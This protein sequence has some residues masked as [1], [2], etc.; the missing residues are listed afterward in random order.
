[1]LADLLDNAGGF[2]I[3]LLSKL[4]N[5]HYWIENVCSLLGMLH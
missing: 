5:T 2:I 1:M 3:N 4:I